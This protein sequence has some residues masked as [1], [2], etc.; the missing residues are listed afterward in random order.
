MC[1]CAHAYG[2]QRTTLGDIP[3]GLAI[4]SFEVISLKGLEL[5]ERAGWPQSPTCLCSSKP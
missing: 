3:Q 4:F 1:L 5:I 2:D